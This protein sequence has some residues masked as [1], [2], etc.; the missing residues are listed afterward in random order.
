MVN[1]A[2]ENVKR[3][4][5]RKKMVRMESSLEF[6]ETH[7]KNKYGATNTLFAFLNHDFIIN[8]LFNK[9][10]FSFIRTIQV[11][12]SFINYIHPDEQ[13]YILKKLQGLLKEPQNLVFANVRILTGE[14]E[15]SLM[16]CMC[17]W[18]ELGSRNAGIVV[19][20]LQHRTK[21]IFNTKKSR[22][23]LIQE[24]NTLSA[25]NL[26]EIV[27]TFDCDKNLVSINSH[28]AVQNLTKYSFDEIKDK[29]KITYIHPED[30]NR[31]DYLFHETYDG[32]IFP[33]EELRII[34]KN[35]VISWHAFTF[36]PKFDDKGDRIGIE[37]FEWGINRLKTAQFALK[38]SEIR[39]KRLLELLP[40]FVCLCN[41]DG[42]ILMANQHSSHFFSNEILTDL[43]GHSLFD[44][45]SFE[46]GQKLRKQFNTVINEEKVK[47]HEYII[48]RE[49]NSIYLDIATSLLRD[50]DGYP[51]AIIVLIR[52]VT[53]SRESERSLRETNQML[54]ALI[55]ASPLAV[56]SVD[57]SLNV[58]LWNDAAEKIFGWSKEEVIGNR[59]PYIPD[60]KED[61]TLEFVH[62]LSKGEGFTDKE[63]TRMTKDGMVVD[64]SISA[65]PLKNEDDLAD[66]SV[67]LVADI[68]EKKVIEKQIYSLA[69]YDHLTKLPNRTLFQD[70]LGQA[71]S[72]AQEHNTKVALMS[73]DLDRFKTFNDSLGHGAGDQLLQKVADRLRTTLR[74][75][76]TVSRQGSDEFMLVLTDL[77]SDDDVITQ[78]DK[79][80]KILSDP[81]EIENQEVYITPS[82]GI[83]IFPS[84]TE[85]T[86]T[87]I[88][89][90]DVAM[91]AA[92]R[93]G[94]NRF[95]FY[96]ADMNVKVLNQHSFENNL[97]KAARNGEFFIEY[98]PKFDLTTKKIV[99]SEA[100]VRWVNNELGIVPPD[101]FI[102]VAEEIG[103]INVIG[104]FVI[105]EACK[106][107]KFWQENGYPDLRIAVNFTVRELGKKLY[108]NIEHALQESRMKAEFLE[109]EITETDI[110]HVDSTILSTIEHIREL[111]VKIA[112][113]DFGTGYSSLSR[114]KELPID[115]I[116]IDQNFIK[117]V[118]EDIRDVAIVSS[119]ATIARN[120]GLKTIAEG[121]E[122]HTTMELLQSFG[123]DEI[124][125]YYISKPVSGDD[126]LSVL[127]K[128]NNKKQK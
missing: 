42:E 58:R 48:E 94:G 83:S 71:I 11:E 44:L 93:H 17:H 104:E 84:D 87:L 40:E 82:I 63:T 118:S 65:A 57:N 53:E 46:T 55:Q 21:P 121:V 91:Y 54:N 30:H 2:L 95:Q 122:N 19:H 77:V 113:D 5:G 1:G 97:R 6:F 112:V 73:I 51:N 109:I 26:R 52:D 69:F 3:N 68:T 45:F 92:K 100:L 7:Y 78:A 18:M 89:Y 16:Y 103:I 67:A 32:H 50:L 108:K 9:T 96:T 31:F 120:L 35:G 123:C 41:I 64:V 79:L 70:R 36:Q 128:Y 22:Q 60:G 90:A 4:K 124:Q 47:G 99:S 110:M 101:R 98:Q 102:P 80:H 59:L 43:S 74:E 111:G 34:T 61:E 13:E 81:F 29:N 106:Q 14:N 62:Q 88:R 49:K 56:I 38:E 85:N 119:I 72:R 20:I 10:T 117:N 76:D 127:Q 12:H 66:G 33:R 25:S 39:Y 105:H 75:V 37:I 126:F 114:L 125:G 86:T 115:Y 107:N 116:K 28:K 24:S 15:Y 27:Y 8:F 23:A